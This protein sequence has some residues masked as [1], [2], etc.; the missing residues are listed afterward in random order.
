MPLFKVEV[1]RVYFVE[2]TVEADDLDHA[3]E[4]GSEISDTM[5]VNHETFI[6][7]EWKAEQVESGV[8]TYIPEQEYLK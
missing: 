4:I 5:E 1:S 2:H 3:Q 7:S 8:V 6:E